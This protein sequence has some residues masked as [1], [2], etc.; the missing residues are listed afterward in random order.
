MGSRDVVDHSQAR[1]DWSS[2]IKIEAA[3]EVSFKP[4][5][6]RKQKPLPTTSTVRICEDQGQRRCA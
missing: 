3:V 1:G 4:P 6:E 2:K 5:E